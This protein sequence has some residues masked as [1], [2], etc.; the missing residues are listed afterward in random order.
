M[1]GCHLV[2]S[3]Q[4]L[5]V[6]QLKD[7]GLLGMVAHFALQKFFE[8]LAFLDDRVKFFSN[9]F[10]VILFKGGAFLI[11][12][13]QRMIATGLDFSD[14]GV[15]SG[16]LLALCDRDLVFNTLE[17]LGASLF[18]HIGDDVL[19]KVKHTVQVATRNIEK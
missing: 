3:I 8:F 5:F 2:A 14:L 1:F 7:D 17:G 15:N 12:T 4:D 11:D 18:V 6:C 13:R 9:D 19:C 16:S 10:V